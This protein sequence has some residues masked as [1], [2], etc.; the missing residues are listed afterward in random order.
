MHLLEWCIQLVLVYVV[1]RDFA[2]YVVPWITRVVS[3]W[4]QASFPTAAAELAEDASEL[5]EDAVEAAGKVASAVA[6]SPEVKEELK[7]AE[8]ELQEAA[9]AGAVGL[10]RRLVSELASS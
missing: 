5:A 1:V 8:E 2:M 3:L 4:V 9:V 10:V 7:H 6:T